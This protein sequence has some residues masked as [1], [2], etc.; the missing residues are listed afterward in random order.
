MNYNGTIQGKADEIL[1]CDI[2][3]LYTEEITDYKVVHVNENAENVNE[4]TEDENNT[5]ENVK[6]TENTE[7]NKTE[8]EEITEQFSTNEHHSSEIND[9]VLYDNQNINARIIFKNTSDN[10]IYVIEFPIYTYSAYNMVRDKIN[11]ILE[12]YKGLIASQTI[13]LNEITYEL[14]YQN[15]KNLKIDY[16][17]IK[18][19]VE[20]TIGTL[21]VYL[22]DQTYIYQTTDIQKLNR[23]VRQLQ[24]AKIKTIEGPYSLK[25]ARINSMKIFN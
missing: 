3:K 4:N 14:H 23:Y 13:T 16:E 21:M 17:K 10:N 1:N 24:E 15:N 11:I 2:A 20:K 7:N 12:P 25:A 19:E 9:F 5:N 22:N 18:K 8:L 6:D